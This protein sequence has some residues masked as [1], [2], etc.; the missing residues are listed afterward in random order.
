MHSWWTPRWQLTELFSEGKFLPWGFCKDR[1]V[2]QRSCALLWVSTSSGCS[3]SALLPAG[4]SLSVGAERGLS[5][6]SGWSPFA[7]WMFPLSRATF[8]LINCKLSSFGPLGFCVLPPKR[9][10]FWQKKREMEVV[11]LQSS[12]AKSHLWIVELLFGRKR[13][14]WEPG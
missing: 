10:L 5:S 14:P 4:K 2:F 1:E 6:F 9:Q 11:Y 12:L 3:A 7:G 13:K 8:T